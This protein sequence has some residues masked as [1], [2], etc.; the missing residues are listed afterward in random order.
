MR[1][2]KE[3]TKNESKEES[4]TYSASDILPTT[5]IFNNED[6]IPKRRNSRLHREKTSHL[7]MRL[8]PLNLPVKKEESFTNRNDDIELY[9]TIYEDTMVINSDR[10]FF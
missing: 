5:V 7:S 3:E 2:Y 10:I 6:V 9:D 1:E 8:Q 4:K